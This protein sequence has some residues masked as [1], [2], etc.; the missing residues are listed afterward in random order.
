[1]DSLNEIRLAALRILRQHPERM[2]EQYRHTLNDLSSLLPGRKGVHSTG[3]PRWLDLCA[4]AGTL[5]TVARQVLSPYYWTAI[6][7]NPSAE[8]ELIKSGVD[9]VVI[10]AWPLDDSHPM[11][12]EKFTIVSLW[13]GI[14][15]FDTDELDCALGKAMDLVEPDGAFLLVFSPFHRGFRFNRLAECAAHISEQASTRKTDLASTKKY[16]ALGEIII[17]VGNNT[18]LDHD[19]WP[20]L[21]KSL[22]RAKTI[23]IRRHNQPGIYVRDE[24]QGAIVLLLEYQDKHGFVSPHEALALSRKYFRKLVSSGSIRRRSGDLEFEIPNDELSLLI[25]F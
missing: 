25:R 2:A 13:H 10:A 1:M 15:Y 7:L 22:R 18:D 12:M 6:D 17:A 4:G 23:Q 9:R 3:I 8:I 21:T 14:Y 16:E 5:T 24:E 20:C 19:R 11:C